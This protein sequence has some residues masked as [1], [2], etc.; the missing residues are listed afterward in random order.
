MIRRLSL[1]FLLILVAIPLMLAPVS[2]QAPTEHRFTIFVEDFVN[3]T[4][5]QPTDLPSPITFGPGRANF[6]TNSAYNWITIQ[7]GHTAPAEATNALKQ[8]ILTADGMLGNHVGYTAWRTPVTG[9][10]PTAPAN[11]NPTGTTNDGK[12]EILIE[13]HKIIGEALSVEDIVDIRWQTYRVSDTGGGND[14]YASIWTNTP[15]QSP[16]PARQGGGYTALINFEGRYTPPTPLTTGDWI[17]NSAQNLYASEHFYAVTKISGVQNTNLSLLTSGP[18]NW[19]TYPSPGPQVTSGN[20]DYRNHDVKAIA[21]ATASSWGY[22][23]DAYLDDLQIEVE[24]SAGNIHLIIINLETRAPVYNSTPAEDSI[25]NLTTTA[26][27]EA[28]EPIS[29]ENIGSET[30]ILNMISL[31]NLGAT[32]AGYVA[33]PLT[34]VPVGGTFDFQFRCGGAGHMTPGN[35][36]NTVLVTH[37]GLGASSPAE[38]TVNCEILPEVGAYDSVPSLSA[39]DIVINTT[40]NDPGSEVL[41]VMNTGVGTLE[42][43]G[44]SSSGDPRIGFNPDIPSP[45][46]PLASGE[47]RDHPVVCLADVGGTLTAQL[48]VIYQVAPGA[49]PVSVSYNVTCNIVD[50]SPP[51]SID[52]DTTQTT[53]GILL[54]GTTF[55]VEQET[56]QITFSADVLNITDPSDPNYE[57]SASNPNNYILLEG[58]TY[59]TSSCATL[60]PNDTQIIPSNVVYDVATRTTTLTYDPA[61]GDGNYRLFI[62]GTTSIVSAIDP[63]VILNGGLDVVIN[64]AVDLQATP[65]PTV[66][67]TATAEPTP[68]VSGSSDQVAQPEEL[69][70]VALPAT[71]ETPFWVDILRRIFGG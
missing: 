32:Q 46:P 52:I 22:Q 66:Q 23:L 51:V 63:T 8:E 55:N 67:P 6:F 39:P 47:T 31:G 9:S 42:I 19:S 27:V 34:S 25:I 4:A 35:Y 45:Y 61:L 29:I 1:L 48:D 28:N 38:Y 59:E 70:V 58:P 60:S 57:D 14:W 11:A 64:F 40:I 7:I 62:C 24:D 65:Q 2:A 68:I 21:F 20:V 56:I 49:S 3:F 16:N 13:P 44:L 30:L 43:L 26:G 37:N 15:L 17:E 33:P 36:T 41:T 71:G 50:D 10:P 53:S 18:I 69:G 54:D 5:V 12:V